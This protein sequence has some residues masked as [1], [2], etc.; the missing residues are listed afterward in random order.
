VVELSVLGD[1]SVEDPLREVI[2]TDVPT[3]GNGVPSKPFDLLNDK[4][5]FLFIEAA[6]IDASVGRR[7]GE[8][9]ETYSLTTT[10]APSFANMMA[11]LRPIPCN[12]QARRFAQN[13]TLGRG[14]Q[15]T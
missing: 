8:I 11:A 9:G 6:Q 10:F 15:R 7:E 13:E 4:L 3:D 1:G 12:R 2:G 14:C 5:S